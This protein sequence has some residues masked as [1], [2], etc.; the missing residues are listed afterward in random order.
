M[1][2]LKTMQ[3]TTEL[4]LSA[5][6]VI[7]L[8]AALRACRL[9]KI[10]GISNFCLSIFSGYFQAIL[11]LTLLTCFSVVN[12][13]ILYIEG[14]MPCFDYHLVLFPFGLNVHSSKRCVCL[15]KKYM[16][17]LKVS[18]ASSMHLYQVVQK[19]KCYGSNS[20]SPYILR[21]ANLRLTVDISKIRKYFLLHA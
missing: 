10:W 4:V 2:H 19:F 5:S 16:E 15:C 9:N 12:C 14:T 7:E 13:F 1:T 11:V 3:S 6:C 18:N 8:V 20:T 17:V 21:G